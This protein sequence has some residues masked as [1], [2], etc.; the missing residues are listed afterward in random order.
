MRLN[1][2]ILPLN[3]IRGGLCQGRTDGMCE[4]GAFLKSQSNA[5]AA[6]NYQYACFGNY[7][8]ANA[9]SAKDF[10]GTIFA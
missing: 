4:I 1:H 6:A 8:V 2:G 7:T 9:T 5:T 10:D 3:T